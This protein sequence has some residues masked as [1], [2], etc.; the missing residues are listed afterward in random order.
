MIV[1][2]VHSLPKQ[3]HDCTNIFFQQNV[4]IERKNKYLTKNKKNKKETKSH[5]CTTN[6]FIDQTKKVMIARKGLCLF[7]F[8]AGVTSLLL[9]LFCIFYCFFS[10]T[11]KSVKQNETKNKQNVVYYLFI[12]ICI[13]LFLLLFLVWFCNCLCLF[14]FICY[15]CLE[16][17][18]QEKTK[19]KKLFYLLF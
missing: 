19:N 9:L 5:D 17:Q 12:V 10:E 13:I 3:S 18:K 6:S 16:K 15:L 8:F 1:R 4:I 11:N 7:C 14:S 2:K